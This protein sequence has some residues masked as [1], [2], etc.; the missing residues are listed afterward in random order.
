MSLDEPDPLIALEGRLAAWLPASGG[1]DRG[2]MLYE[3]GRAAAT[4]ERRGA[5][6]T[7][8]AATLTLGLASIALATGWG[9][10][11]R[12]AVAPESERIAGRPDAGLARSTPDLARPAPPRP[13]VADERGR[14]FAATS[15]LELTRR[16]ADGRFEPEVQ[17][18]PPGGG[19]ADPPES[20]PIRV[21]DRDR[22]LNL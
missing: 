13:Q 20:A 22:F 14:P 21:G 9:L 19:S 6:R 12:R 7:L 5:F 1:L 3:A 4:A 8:A 17:P 16:I 18:R 11:R 15:Y 10:E 2:R